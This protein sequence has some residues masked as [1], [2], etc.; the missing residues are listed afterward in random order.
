MNIPADPLL[1]PFELRGLKLRNR[2]V[3][4]PMTRG[5]SPGGVP[6]RNVAGYY[7]RRA[8]R[9]VGL[10]ITEGT[11]VDHPAALGAGSMN[12]DNVPVLHGDAAL[13]GWQNVVGSVHAAGGL[14]FPQ[15]WHM[16]PIR[17]ANSGPSPA[18]PSCRPSGI[19]GPNGLAPMPPAYLESMMPLTEAMSDSEIADVIA[20]FG[21]S[22]ANAKAVG[23]DGIA[24]H[25]AHGYL[26]D[27]FFWHETNQRTDQWGGNVAARTRFGAEVVRSIRRAVGPALPIMLRFSQWK[28]QNYSG[29]TVSTP[30]QLESMVGI[31]ADAGVD[32]FDAST[33]RYQEP[34]FADSPLTLAG[35]TKK[36]SGKPCMAV[37]GVG[38]QKDLQGT[39][40]NGSEAFDNLADVRSRIAS[41]EFD[42]VAV[43][44]SILGDPD[45][46]NKVERREP[47]QRFN[48]QAFATLE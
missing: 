24:I 3:M 8:E 23:F 5:F 31:L 42:L 20:G 43:G 4:S 32:I 40:E 39:F 48:L 36:L 2:I 41:G 7:T 22:A 27:S 9:K 12:E 29:Q 26:I 28:L 25:G 21:R 46:V 18:A 13:K 44:R 38:L 6:G 33:R 1:T 15:L 34:A 35:W 17:Q 45:W 14:I 11:G 37:G 16:G 47:L 30:A 19:W 10:I